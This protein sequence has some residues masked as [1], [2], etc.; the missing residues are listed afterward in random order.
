M[1]EFNGTLRYLDRL[2]NDLRKF[3]AN[4]RPLVVLFEAIGDTPWQRKRMAG[5]NF[6]NLVMFGDWY[7]KA[8]KRRR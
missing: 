2:A 6:D 1:M 7:Q 5:L 8:K 3:T 4:G